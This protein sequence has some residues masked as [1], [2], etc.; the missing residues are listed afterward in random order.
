MLFTLYFICFIQNKPQKNAYTRVLELYSQFSDFLYYGKQNTF[1]IDSNEYITLINIY[2]YN[3]SNLNQSGA[4]K[5]HS[6][7][8]SLA[9]CA[10]SSFK[11][12]VQIIETPK[13]R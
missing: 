12:N 11:A 8:E 6:T 13:E 7:H 9:Y 3:T 10:S 2:I 4:L 5:L 1:I